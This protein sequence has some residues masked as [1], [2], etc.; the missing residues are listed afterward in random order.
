VFFTPSLLSRARAMVWCAGLPGSMSRSF[1]PRSKPAHCGRESLASAVCNNGSTFASVH[2]ELSDLGR[3]INSTARSAAG[4]GL[5][6][7]QGERAPGTRRNIDHSSTR[8]NGILKLFA[9]ST[10]LS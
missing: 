8:A 9:V 5:T 1:W 7:L 2:S 3:G 10:I 4:R 6:F